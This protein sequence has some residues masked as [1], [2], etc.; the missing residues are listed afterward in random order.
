MSGGQAPVIHIGN[1]MWNAC[2][3]SEQRVAKLYDVLR[4]RTQVFVWSEFPP[5]LRLAARLPIRRIEPSRHPVG[6]TLVV[7]GCYFP[8]G[9]WLDAAQPERV[10]LVVNTVA[11]PTHLA[12][13]KLVSRTGRPVELVFTSETTRLAMGSPGR[14]EDSPIDMDRFAP[15]SQPRD[16]SR[17]VV[18]RL[19]RDVD[20]KHHDEDPALYSALARAGCTV[21]IMGGTCLSQRG[22]GDEVSLLREGAI[23]AER[24]LQGLDCFV[25]RTGMACVEAFGRVVM[26]AMASGLPVVVHRRGGPAEVVEDG[27]TGLLFDTTAEATEQILRLRR[28]AELRARLGKAAREATVRR[29]SEDYWTRLAAYYVEGV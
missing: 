20:S 3:G 14:M 7:V 16:A 29:Y 23:P 17:F 2:G 28:D 24:F 22:C 18:G 8:F 19:S 9:R 15:A 6:G 4:A 25:Y 13:L 1:P 5:D 21:N 10:I 27:E 26:E 12:N 11:D